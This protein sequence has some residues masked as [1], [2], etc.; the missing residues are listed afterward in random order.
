MSP[1]RSGVAGSLGSVRHIA[2]VGMMG[3]GKSETG[4]ELA[5]ALGRRFVDCDGL[6]ADAAGCSIPE[7]FAAEGEA[8][9]RRRE[10]EVLAGVLASTGAAVIAT[11]GGVVTVAG[12]RS[13]LAGAAVCWLRARPETLAARVGDGSGRPMLATGAAGGATLDRL[14]ELAADRDRWYLE[15]ADVVVDVDDL[16]VNQAALAVASRLGDLDGRADGRVCEA[17]L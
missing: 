14:R 3:S 8:G 4:Q 7:I 9:F 11:G 13:Q 6:V 2:L 10:S 5:L 17:T 12:N 16:S 1:G 15:V